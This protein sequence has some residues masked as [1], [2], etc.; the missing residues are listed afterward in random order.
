MM[1]VQRPANL[2][3]IFSAGVT[4]SDVAIIDL[5]HPEAPRIVNYGELEALCNGVAN[6]LVRAG[7]P[8][9]GRVGLMASN[10]VAALAVMLGAMRAGRVA[11]PVNP[12]AG[13]ETLAY[14]ATDS[15][16]LLCFAD[17]ASQSAI[18]SGLKCIP[19]YGADF[20]AF[21]GETT[22]EPHL[23]Q[24]EETA[25]ILYT[26]G[27]TGQP[28]GV[29]LSHASQVLIAWGY[30]T[31]IVD[32]C[33]RSGPGIVAAPLF[34]MNAT[35]SVTLNLMMRGA[36]V[37]LPRFEAQAFMDALARY[38]CSM[39]SG[40][41]TMVSL[42]AQKQAAVARVDLSGVKLVTIGSAP[43]SQTVL[44]QVHELFPSA[45]VINSY[46]TTET[47]AGYFGAHPD[48]KP[49]P[50]MSVG[51]P[52]PHAKLRLTG[53]GAPDQ[54]VLEVYCA[55]RMSGY[56]NRP[57]LTAAK[58]RDGWIDTGDIMRR[59]A[60]G[61][62]YFIGRDDDMFV[63][64]GENIYPGQVERLLERHPDVLEVCVMPLADALRGHIPVAFVVARPN[65]ALTEQLLKEFAL[66][67]AAPHLHPR[68]IWFIDR[69]PLAGTNKIDRFA[70][71]A[72]MA[73]L[74]GLG[75]PTVAGVGLISIDARI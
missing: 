57:E 11:V 41:P 72:Q 68:K 21:L 18:P 63:C 73:Q 36:T 15:S 38:H 6:G 29:L 32:E 56:L 66:A 69:M 9:G 75:R 43:L 25:L 55:T 62:Y 12:R 71:K 59:D 60:D 47:G 4:P 44:A 24:L 45:G 58:L 35:V 51:Y 2:G 48:G 64:S 20:A 1:P 61:W 37:L 16:M 31:P 26:S 40:V 5:S 54:G 39:V 30:A 7:V 13:A 33:L 34:H 23:P 65:A 46:G 8:V 17:A 10:S 22:F 50:A 74:A 14:M 27:S 19:L 3:C 53:Q 70:L 28:K 42:L 49:R 67:N 52:Q